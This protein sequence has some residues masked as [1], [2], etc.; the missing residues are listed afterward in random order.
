MT[1]EIRDINELEIDTQE[2]ANSNKKILSDAEE[3]DNII[4]EIKRNWQNETGTDIE[5]IITELE[6]CT[7]KLKNTIT[8]TIEKYVNTMNKLIVDSKI[9]QNNSI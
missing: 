1:Y 8:P 2:L 5:S 6:N 9:A 3:L 4:M 7:N